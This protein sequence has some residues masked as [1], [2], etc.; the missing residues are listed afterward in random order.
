MMCLGGLGWGLTNPR[1]GES[2]GPVQSRM[3]VEAW[4]LA[5]LTASC[6]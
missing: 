2:E 4:S 1:Q 5:T 6:A 3:C